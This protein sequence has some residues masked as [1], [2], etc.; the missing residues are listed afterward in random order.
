MWER[1]DGV[2]PIRI[3]EPGG[4]RRFWR[5]R[6]VI[7]DA[8]ENPR[9]L[10]LGH[11]HAIGGAAVDCEDQLNTVF[12]RRS[13][14]PLRNAVAVTITLR[15]VPLGDRPDRAECS[16]HDCRP[17]E[18]VSIKVAHHKY[19]LPHFAGGSQARNQARR[20]RKKVRIVQ[21]AVVAIKELAREQ[22]VGKSAALEECREREVQVLRD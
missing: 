6:V 10:R 2:R 5:H 9:L 4:P 8:N 21:G 16:N 14:C 15:D 17:S 20:I 3:D 18:S 7:N 11:A 13:N 12:T 1:I 19:G 22:R